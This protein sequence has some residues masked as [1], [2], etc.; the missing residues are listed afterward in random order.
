[1]A[2]PPPT[3]GTGLS[4]PSAHDALRW[5]GGDAGLRS[6]LAPVLDALLARGP[7]VEVLR[8]KAGRRRLARARLASGE[9]L[10][11]KHFAARDPGWKRRLGLTASA[12]E[13]R[14]LTSLRAAGVAVPEALAHVETASGDEVVVTRFLEGEP[15]ADALARLPAAERRALLAALG[16]LVRRLHASGRIHRDLHRENVW[17]TAEGP[18]LIDLQQGLPIAPPWLRRRDQGELDASLAPLLSLADRVRL[19]AHLLGVE[20]PFDASARAAIRAIGRA[21]EARHRSHVES[22]TRRSLREGRLYVPLRCDHGRGMRLREVSEGDAVAALGAAGDTRD[23]RGVWL[24]GH[25]LRARGIGAPRPLAFAGSRVALAHTPPGAPPDDAGIVALGVALR[26]HDVAIAEGAE[27]GRDEQGRLGPL[28]LEGV[29]FRSRLSREEAARV[30][31][32]VA[33]HVA[34]PTAFERYRTRLRFYD[35]ETVTQRK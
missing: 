26:R 30:D 17:V 24:A 11:L 29:A 12:R 23:A 19:R 20:R 3:A 22:R 31:A 27:P 15:L 35:V 14:A 34:D 18:V 10:F 4:E 9:R 8:E 16:A 21:S 28:P 2:G 25:G 5:R 32:F 1:M 33:R 6:R 7:G 13:F